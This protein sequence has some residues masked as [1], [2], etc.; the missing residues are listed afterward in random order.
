MEGEE[1]RQRGGLQ[2]E[3]IKKINVLSMYT[4]TNAERGY[5]A[6]RETVAEDVKWPRGLNKT[7]NHH[8]IE[9]TQWNG[10]VNQHDR[11]GDK[12]SHASLPQKV[13][14]L[15]LCCILTADSTFRLLRAAV[16]H[17]PAALT[18]RSNELLQ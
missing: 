18:C 7:T 13:L 1:G 8:D 9:D 6:S 5:L 15:A 3:M 10:A 16:C 17:Y 12:K 14:N 2:G 11:A 4:H